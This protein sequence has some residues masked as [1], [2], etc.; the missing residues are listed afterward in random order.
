MLIENGDG[1]FI[2]GPFD[3]LTILH[4]RRANRFHAAFFEE[5]PMPGPIEKNPTVIRLKSKMHHTGG[6]P[7]LEGARKHLDELAEKIKVPEENI[8]RDPHDWDA[9][10]MA[11]VW[12][13]PNWKK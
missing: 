4:D 9:Q 3:V 10:K 2:G 13:V 7:D 12:A 1:T 6:S 11:A 8:W 5:K